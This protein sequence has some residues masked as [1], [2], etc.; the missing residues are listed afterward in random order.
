MALAAH[1]GAAGRPRQIWLF[2]S[3]QGLPPPSSKDGAAEQKH[4]FEGLN[5]GAIANVGRAFQKLGL[6]LENT[7]ITPG[8]F[9][10]TLHKAP[11]EQIAVLHID[12][13][14]YES[15]KVVLDIFYD[16]VM[17]GGFVALDD[18]GY[19]EGCKR[20]LDDFCAERGLAAMELVRTDR[21][22]AYFQK[23]RAA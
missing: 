4:Y 18:Y 7:H 9:N 13:D 15:V 2:D 14:W 11:I 16:R 22:G 8:W 5:K 3:F 23:P 19:W 20:A 10:E 6:T 21:V 12:A 17:P 1:E